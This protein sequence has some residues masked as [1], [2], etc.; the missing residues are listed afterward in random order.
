MSVVKNKRTQGDLQVLNLS[1]NP[2][3]HTMT[4]CKNETLFPKRQRWL[5]CNRLI[6]ASLEIV[7]NV[8][9]ANAILVQTRFDYMLRREHQNKA[10]AELNS[11]YNLLE[12]AL[13]FTPL[14]PSEL[15]YWCTMVKETDDALKHWMR[16]DADRYKDIRTD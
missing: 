8:R 16:S 3:S 15:E 13:D 1:K 10:H 7:T 11:M 2:L 9:E 6:N 4:K 5:L 12:V 14:S